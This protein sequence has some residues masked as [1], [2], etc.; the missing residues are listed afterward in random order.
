MKKAAATH[1]SV[2]EP[3]VLVSIDRSNPPEG[4]TGKDWYTYVIAQGDKTIEGQRRG[5]R[6]SLT[7]SVEEMIERLNE[8][9]MGK[10]GRNHLR[11]A[12]KNKKA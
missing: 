8:R 5:T 12:P 9:R 3:F 2:G 6:A 7:E 10:S 4:A 11:L 1:R